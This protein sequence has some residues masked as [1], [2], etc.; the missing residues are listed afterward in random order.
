MAAKNALASRSSRSASSPRSPARARPASG[1]MRSSSVRSGFS[2]PVAKSLIAATCPDAEPAPAA[3]VGERGV[4]EAVEQQPLAR[5]QARQQRFGGEL[6]P[7]GR[8]EEGL[9]ARVD[10]ERGV[11]DQRADALGQ[12]DAA[13]LAQDRDRAASRREL[14]LQGSDE[15][16]LAGPVDALDGDEAAAWHGGDD[17][18]EAR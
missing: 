11:L 12:L 4:D 2:A 5:G 18:E 13:G 10:V 6:R 15:G 17:S 8:V 16:G 7:R 3:L 9:G 1:S 14:S